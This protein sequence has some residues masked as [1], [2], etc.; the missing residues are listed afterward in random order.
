MFRILP[1]VAFSLILLL[2]GAAN[3]ANNSDTGDITAV[4]PASYHLLDPAWRVMEQKVTAFVGQQK[5][6]EVVD[7]AYATVAA[8]VCDKLDVDEKTLDKEFNLLSAD[9]QK[10]SSPGEQAQFEKELMGYYG[11][12]VGLIVAESLQNKALFC[13]EVEN[14]KTKKGGPSRYWS[15]VSSTSK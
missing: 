14:V 12:Y 2:S 13:K 5:Q 4:A 7:M 15:A 9:M 10:K 3:A 8:D 1:A 6:R 11:V